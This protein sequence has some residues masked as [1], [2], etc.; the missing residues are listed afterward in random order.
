MTE[1]DW[2]AAFARSLGVFLSGEGIPYRDGRGERV[3]DDSFYVVVN[4]HHERLDFVLPEALGPVPWTLLVDTGDDET[5]GATIA[6]GATLQ[7][8]GRSVVVLARPRPR[9]SLIP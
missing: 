2:R 8:K 3:V 5:H 1:E 7:T 4:G 9:S 6:S